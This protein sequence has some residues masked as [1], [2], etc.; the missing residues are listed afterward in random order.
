MKKFQKNRRNSEKKL[1]FGKKNCRKKEKYKKTNWK[2]QAKRAPKWR[3][4]LK[5]EIGEFPESRGTGM[6]KQTSQRLQALSAENATL[7]TFLRIFLQ[8]RIGLQFDYGLDERIE[9][10]YA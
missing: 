7:G 4:K 2:I 10:Q 1:I 6:I 5:F 9:T 3:E 8:F